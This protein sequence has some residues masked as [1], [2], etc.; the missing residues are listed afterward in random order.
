MRLFYGVFMD[1]VMG[2][3]SKEFFIQEQEVALLAF[4]G[5]L[6]SSTGNDR[7]RIVAEIDRIERYLEKAVVK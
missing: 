7:E 1:T 6:A 2:I 4:R 5:L 3:D